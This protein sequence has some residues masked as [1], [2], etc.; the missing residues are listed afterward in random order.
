MTRYLL[1]KT[2]AMQLYEKIAQNF[3]F[4]EIGETALGIPSHSSTV[5]SIINMSTDL[6]V[7]DP[8][9]AATLPSGF[10]PT[11]PLR[12]VQEIPLNKLARGPQTPAKAHD[13]VGRIDHLPTTPSASTSTLRV[14]GTVPSRLSTRTR[15]LNFGVSL[16]GY[17]LFHTASPSFVG[18]ATNATDSLCPVRR[19]LWSYTGLMR[20]LLS[21]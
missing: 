17:P 8:R 5:L 10:I 4:E 13:V 21:P 14:S 12:L 3:R 9:R 7:M 11:P 18:R 20:S 2:F 15:G 19:A 1:V 6:G 16:R